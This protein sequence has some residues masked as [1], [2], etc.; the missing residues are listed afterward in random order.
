MSEKYITYN[1][2]NNIECYYTYKGYT[3]ENLIIFC[4]SVFLS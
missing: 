2:D 4:V 1:I 3:L